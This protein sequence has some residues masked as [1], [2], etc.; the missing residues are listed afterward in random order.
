LN[1]SAVLNVRSN[2]TYMAI[3]LSFFLVYTKAKMEEYNLH[4]TPV[5]IRCQLRFTLSDLPWGLAKRMGHEIQRIQFMLDVKAIPKYWANGKVSHRHPNAA[6]I[7]GRIDEI[8]SRAIQLHDAYCK[9]GRFPDNEA[10]ML[11]IMDGNE[12]KRESAFFEDYARYIEYLDNRKV[13][14]DFVQRQRHVC[15]LLR[16]FQKKTGYQVEYATVGRTFAEKFSAWVIKTQPQRQHN[17]DLAK[18]AMRYLET[19]KIFCSH[20]FLEQWTNERLFQQIS[21]QFK[22]NPF[23]TTLTLAEIQKLLALQAGDIKGIPQIQR[24]AIM[25]RDWFIFATQSGIRYSDWRQ[26]RFE[27]IDLMP[28]GMNIRFVQEK[29]DNPLEVPLSRIGIEILQRNDFQMPIAFGATS[30]E[31]HLRLLAEAA[32]IKKH[33]TTHTARRTF[34]TLQE[35]SGVPRSVI[36]RIS[37]H[38]TEKEYL[39]YI[40]VSF[41]YNADMMRKANPGWFDLKISG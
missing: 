13:S 16:V 18:T 10:Y 24:N 30:T 20:A 17:Q 27:L 35:K 37:G 2:I 1:N 26:K 34:C 23:P 41:E 28:A 31:K 29:T 9:A 15:E 7:N 5:S 19:L 8:N 12:A 21:V 38:K 3:G 14:P 39:K 4:N 11:A 6:V 36:M 40:G 32:G 33:I 22:P 25:T